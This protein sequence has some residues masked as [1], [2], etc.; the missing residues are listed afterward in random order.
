MLK[1]KKSRRVED[2]KTEDS[3][4]LKSSCWGQ[5]KKKEVE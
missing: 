3:L 1:L 4:L 5:G 2:E